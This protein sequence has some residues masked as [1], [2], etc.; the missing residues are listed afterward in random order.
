M[1][2]KKNKNLHLGA[3]KAL[4]FIKN[5]LKMKKIWFLKNKG[6]KNLKKKSLAN[7]EASN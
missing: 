7:L 1:V 5:G 6:V 3:S 4:K 2:S